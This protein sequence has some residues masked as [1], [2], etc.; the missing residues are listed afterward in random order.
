L[1]LK[2]NLA[3][4]V[5]GTGINIYNVIRGQLN[6]TFTL[7]EGSPSSFVYQWTEDCYNFPGGTNVG[8]YNTSV[9]TVQSLNDAPHTLKIDMLS[10]LLEPT[11]TKATYS[12]FFFRLCSDIFSNCNALLSAATVGSVSPLMMAA[13]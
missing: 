4:A 11:V 8:C 6:I 3:L 7:D 5:T 2:S 9:Y 13:Y 12:D 1:E 10:Y